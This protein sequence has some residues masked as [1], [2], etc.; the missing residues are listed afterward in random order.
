M[1]WTGFGLCSQEKKGQC[2]KPVYADDCPELKDWM[3]CFVE[4]HGMHH[5]KDDPEWGY[6]LLRFRDGEVTISDID[7]INKSVVNSQ[8]KLP[9]DIKYATYCNKDR[10][11][12][13]AALFQEQCKTLHQMTGNNDDAIMIFSDSIRAQ[14]SAKVYKPF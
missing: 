7:T 2:E 10:D 6:L 9:K 13:N 1:E 14:D 3:N 4:L 8:T 5:F 12:I 11:S